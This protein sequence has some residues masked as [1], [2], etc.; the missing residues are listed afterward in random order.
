MNDIEEASTALISILFA[1]DS[2]FMSTMNA[3]FPTSKF[4]ETFE[5]AINRELSKIYDWLAVNKLS[6]NARKTK[7]MIFHTQGTKFNFIP[8]IKIN[9]TSIERVSDFVFL[10]LTVNE[11]LSWKSHVD[12]IANKL[13]K[14]SGILCRLKH[15]LP[16]HILRMIYCSLIQS[17]LNFSLLTWGFDCNRLIKLQKKIIRIITC[18]KYNAHTEPLFK[19]LELL[20][21]KDMI[22]LNTLKFYWKLKN[23][24]VPDYFISY[25]P[26]TQEALHGRDT[27]FNQLIS[28]NTVRIV[29]QEKRLRNYLPEVLNSTE[30]IILEKVHTHS[31]EGFSHYAKSLIIEK[32]SLECTV[33]NCYICSQSN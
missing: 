27:R 20:K 26:Q 16:T 32:Y 18:S 30:D 23:N 3:T 28:R 11:K 13:S 15:F 9:G 7:F 33:Q 29:T 25:Q 2:T 8:N 6:L 1:D 21:L 12:K 5:I 22:T 19:I 10:G 14:Y 17:N 31:Y 24:K 4:D